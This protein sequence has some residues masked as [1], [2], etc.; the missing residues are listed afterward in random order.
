M[1]TEFTVAEAAEMTGYTRARLYQ[2]VKDQQIAFRRVRVRA[3]VRIPRA[4]VEELRA[5]RL[6]AQNRAGGGSA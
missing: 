1:P 2:L 3:D 6:G 4:T 5:R